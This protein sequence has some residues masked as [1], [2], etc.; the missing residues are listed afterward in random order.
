MDK[1][2]FDNLVQSLQEAKAIAK[3]EAPA[4][5]RFEL[6]APDA[7]TVR[8]EIGL[9]QSEF[10]RLMRVSVKTLQNWEQHRRNPTGPAAALLKV[11]SMSPETVL[12]SLHA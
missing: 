3:G 5:R 12:K 4:S 2:L 1:E 8:Q 7:K 6:S 9:S 10:A 11:V